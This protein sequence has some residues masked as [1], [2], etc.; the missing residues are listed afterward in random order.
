MDAIPRSSNSFHSA[1]VLVEDG[2]DLFTVGLRRR[3]PPAG[4]HR[5]ELLQQV[6]H[7]LVLRLHEMDQW[8]EFVGHPLQQL[9]PEQVVFVGV[10]VV[11]EAQ[12]ELD[13]VG[14]LRCALP[15]A[16]GGRPDFARAQSDLATEAPVDHDHHPDIG[17]AGTVDG[18]SVNRR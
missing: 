15:V 2:G 4:Q 8:R 1:S 3:R 13:V 17:E 5:R 7:P 14:D 6:V 9:V 10:V 12:E 18:G 16:I 11:Q